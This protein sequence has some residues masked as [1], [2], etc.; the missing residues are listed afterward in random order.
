MK[1]A[2]FKLLALLTV[3]LL[4]TGCKLRGGTDTGNP[5]RDDNSAIEDP[6]LTFTEALIDRVCEKRLECNP[7]VIGLECLSGVS[8]QS[9]IDS[10]IGLPEDLFEDLFELIRAEKSADERLQ[11]NLEEAVVCFLFIENLTCDSGEVLDSFDETLSDPFVP[12]Y[13]MLSDQCQAVYSGNTF[14]E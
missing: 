3:S 9:N 7:D 13:L 12:T 1:S 8:R 2:L 4:F 11:L 5:L 6:G 10:E 14:I